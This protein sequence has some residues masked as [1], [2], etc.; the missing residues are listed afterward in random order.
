M[1]PSLQYGPTALKY[2]VMALGLYQACEL[3]TNF[4][5][6]AG[7]W[8]SSDTIADTTVNNTIVAANSTLNDYSKVAGLWGAFWSCPWSFSSES[9]RCFQTGFSKN[10]VTQTVS[11]VLA[12]IR[13]VGNTGFCFAKESGFANTA[14]CVFGLDENG[15]TDLEEKVHT[16]FVIALLLGCWYLTHQKKNKK[17]NEAQLS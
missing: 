11:M 12:P 13:F 3:A 6:W 7:S 8:L 1:V 16:I 9:F 4:K 10:P 17:K 14:G 5:I 2:V 15:K